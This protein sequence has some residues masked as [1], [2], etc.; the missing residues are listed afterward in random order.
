VGAGALVR[1]FFIL[2]VCFPLSCLAQRNWDEWQAEIVSIQGQVEIENGQG[3]QS[4]ENGD[5]VCT[6]YAVRVHRFSRAAIRLP[7]KTMLRLDQDTSVTFSQPRDDT[8]SWL[9]VL[10]GVIH[11]ISRDPRAL[12][13]NTPYANAGL[14]GTEFVIAVGDD[15]T[16]V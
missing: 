4:V 2:A 13:F 7:D 8:G 14:E 12:R 6:G 3:W 10:R 5:K 15:R 9:D 16:D 11:V 1:L